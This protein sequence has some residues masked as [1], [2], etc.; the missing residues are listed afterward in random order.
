[1]H[2]AKFL[3]P[4]ALCV[5]SS[6]AFDAFIA[7]DLFPDKDIKISPGFARTRAKGKA[8]IYD[9]GEFKGITCGLNPFERDRIPAD[10]RLT[11]TEPTDLQFTVYADYKDPVIF[12]LSESKGICRIQQHSDRQEDFNSTQIW[13]EDMPAGTYLIWIVNPKGETNYN[14]LIEEH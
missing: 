3:I 7:E 2:L 12:I 9:D 14:L 6:T 4:I 1:M 5:V 13:W 11:L 8:H 10:H